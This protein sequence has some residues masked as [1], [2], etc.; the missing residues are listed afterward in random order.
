M[1]KR[2]DLMALQE[3]GSSGL[4]EFGGVVYEEFL[5]QL[6]GTRGIKI[7]QEM[8]SNDAVIGAILFVIDMLIRQVKWD[9]VPFSQ[10][11]GDVNRAEFLKTVLSDMS[12]T[13][14]DTISEIMS[15]LTYGWSYHEIVYKVRLGSN[16]DSSL[17]SK[18]S[19]GLIGWRKLPIRSQ[20]TLYEW[21]FDEHAGLQGMVQSAPPDWIPKFIPVEKA[22]LFRTQV[23]KGNPEGRS[24]LRNAYRSWYF[25]KHI[26]EIEGIGIERDLAGLPVAWVPPQLL[27]SKATAED[28]SVLSAVKKIVTNVRRDEQEGI[29]FPLVYDET[30]HKAYDFALLSTGGRRNFDTGAVISRY[31]QRIAMTVLADFILLGQ[32]NVGS[33]AL[34]SNKTTLFA[35]ALG[36]WLDSIA[37]V[38]NRY[39]I[40]RLFK[41]N[42]YAEERLPEL[43]PG[44]I[45]MPSLTELGEYINKLSGAGINLSQDVQLE[46]HL[47]RLAN[48]PP[49]EGD[50]A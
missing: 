24:I 35:T 1:P 26:E 36:A 12:M 8:S 31:D 22:L 25:K 32:S 48:L 41:L 43:K 13:W 21:R 38:F 23:R 42:G 46:N 39:A 18:Y 15:M 14:E 5:K 19:D 29:I 2:V 16:A 3:I 33:F 7:Y 9:V 30:G 47:R 45:V 27:S 28:L 40:P 11:S 6:Q 20:D 37:A 44:D 50:G 49:K 34:S 4:N 17:S 10:E